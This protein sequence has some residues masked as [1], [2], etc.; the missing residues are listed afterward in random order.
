MTPRRELAAVVGLLLLAA[1]LRFTGLSFGQPIPAYAPQD[2][3]LDTIHL[4]TP[5]H[6]DEFLFVQRPLRMLL[7]GELNPKFFHNPSFL[8]NTNFVVFALTDE[9]NNLVWE[10][11]EAY[12]ARRQAPF[13]LF[14]TGRTFSALGGVLAVAATYAAGRVLGGS[15]TGLAAAGIVAVSVPLVQHAHYSTTSSL[16]AGFVA[17]CLW[18]TLLA[19]QRFRPWAFALA[20]IGAGLAAGSRYNAAA[21]SL[22]VFF[23][24]WALLYQQRTI[25]RAGWVLLGWVLFPVTFLF[26]TPHVVFDTAFFLEEFRFIT[27][28]YIGDEVSPFNVS[29]WV[30][31][32]YELRYLA[33]YGLGL[34]GTVTAVIGVIIAWRQRERAVMTGLLLAYLL[35][36]AYVVLRTIRP[37]GADQMLTPIIPAVALLAALGADTVRRWVPGAVIWTVLVAPLLVYSLGVV[38][39]F[40]S[41]DT[42]YDLHAWAWNHLP[43]EAHVHLLGPYNVPLDETRYTVTRTYGTGEVVTPDDL[44]ALGADYVIVSD[45]WLQH[46]RRASFIDAAFRARMLAVPQS[47]EVE[48]QQLHTITRPRVPGDGDPLHSATYWHQPGL[49]VYC[50]TDTACAAVR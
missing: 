35:P 39:L 47:L 4:D 16:A 2:T 49:T 8:I 23:A 22:V 9:R 28:Q 37:L 12:G 45:A 3:A 21:V 14:I 15:F 19:V 40:A 32:S 7:T 24:G 29:P 33:I 34:P 13:R 41:P 10:G 44:R 30:G 27:N 11:R 48:L 50:L 6:P 38:S 42:R 17:L 5:L 36:Y 20:G 25:Q 46:F 31:L 1:A 43:P 26:T 18:S